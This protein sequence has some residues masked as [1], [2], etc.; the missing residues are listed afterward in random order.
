MT[1]GTTEPFGHMHCYQ[2][3]ALQNGCAKEGAVKG[4]KEH[5]NGSERTTAGDL[6]ISF[7]FL[8]C[9]SRIISLLSA[10]VDTRLSNK[11]MFKASE[12]GSNVNPWVLRVMQEYSCPSPTHVPSDLEQPRQGCLRELKRMRDYST[13]RCK[14]ANQAKEVLFKQLKLDNTALNPVVGARL[15]LEVPQQSSILQR[16]A[17]NIASKEPK[18]A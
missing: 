16:R 11:K 4:R 13:V 12:F 14:S 2:N 1:K 3:K 7:P 9:K 8:T 15:L 10:F 17:L 18:S 5:S 6:L